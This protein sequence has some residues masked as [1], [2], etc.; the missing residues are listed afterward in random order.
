M[1]KHEILESSI[2]T[3]QPES[4]SERPTPRW[5]PHKSDINPPP[6]QMYSDEFLRSINR[7][8]AIFFCVIVIIA[9]IMA[10]T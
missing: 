6:R 4:K 1:K 7:Q 8:G 3:A 5:T 9:I 2:Q 10:I